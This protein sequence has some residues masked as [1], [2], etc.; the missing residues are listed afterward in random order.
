VG[1]GLI[2]T[3][4]SASITLVERRAFPAA[5]KLPDEAAYGRE[6]KMT[7]VKWYFSLPVTEQ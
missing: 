3:K 2:S 5:A 1:A 7:D 4:F 6:M